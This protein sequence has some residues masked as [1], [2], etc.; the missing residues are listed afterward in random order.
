MVAD[1]RRKTRVAK[2]NGVAPSR[3]VVTMSIGFT[4]PLCGHS[5][6]ITEDLWNLG[7]FVVAASG[8]DWTNCNNMFPVQSKHVLGVG[9]TNSL[10]RCL[11]RTT[12]DLVMTCLHLVSVCGQHQKR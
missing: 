2:E 12:M 5:K 1:I 8:N 3:F 4:S 11:N 7:A 9:A 10:E 6:D